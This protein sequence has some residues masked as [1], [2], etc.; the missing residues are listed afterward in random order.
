MR[1]QFCAAK[2]MITLSIDYAS[3]QNT[4]IE[5]DNSYPLSVK[6]YVAKTERPVRRFHPRQ[7]FLPRYLG[8]GKL[9]TSLLIDFRRFLVF[10]ALAKSVST[11]LEFATASAMPT[12]AFS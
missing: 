5:Y 9:R 10:I 1:H 8:I 4:S 7:L 2:I 11:G 3:G 12:A 6:N